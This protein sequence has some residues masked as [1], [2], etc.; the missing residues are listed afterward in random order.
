M[1]GKGSWMCGGI[2]VWVDK[3]SLFRM[4]VYFGIRVLREKECVGMVLKDEG[5]GLS[6]WFKVI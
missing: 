6:F 3:M 5:V 1:G 2:G 4:G